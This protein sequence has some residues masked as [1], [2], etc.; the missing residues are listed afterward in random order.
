MRQRWGKWFWD[1]WENDPA[2]KLCSAAAQGL[3]MRMLCIAAKHDPVGYVA[4]GGKPVT[5]EELVS[6]TGFAMQEVN[7]GLVDLESHGVFSRDR[8]KR[9]YSRRMVRDHKKAVVA[10]QNGKLGGAP[11]HFKQK[12]IS[13]SATP[14]SRV[15]HAR[16]DSAS[17]SKTLKKEKGGVGEKGN[18]ITPHPKRG[19]RFDRFWRA[20]PHKVGKRVAEQAF[21]KALR[22]ASLDE[23]LAGL[24]RYK[25]T[26][27]PERNWCNPL[28]FLNEDRWLDEPGPP[29]VNGK[30]VAGDEFVPNDD[31]KIRPLLAGYRGT[32]KHDPPVAEQNGRTGFLLPRDQVQRSRQAR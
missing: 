5:V 19:S 4:I 12:E 1:D 11:S 7:D 24:E 20:Y 27:P 30:P 17:D 26:K 18:G 6:I 3:W 28:T 29:A 22:R 10:Q 31:P 25:A 15:I 14:P 16:S 8:Y 32:H 9:I 23:I 13:S 21:G 2:L